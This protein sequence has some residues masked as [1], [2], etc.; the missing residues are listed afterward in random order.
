MH[1]AIS[2]ID[3]FLWVADRKICI[4]ALVTRICGSS[5]IAFIQCGN[6]CGI[7]DNTSPPTAADEFELAVPGLRQPDLDT[8]FRI[9]SRLDDSRN[10]TEIRN[11]QHCRRRERFAISTN[12]RSTALS[13]RRRGWREYTG[14]YRLRHRYCCVWKRNRFQA[15]AW[16]R[17]KGRTEEHGGNVRD[18]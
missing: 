5:G 9:G 8:D 6:Q 7:A 3:E 16:S 4:A 17:R 2:E 13:T 18:H 11:S 15:G 10:A 1:R 14:G 12:L